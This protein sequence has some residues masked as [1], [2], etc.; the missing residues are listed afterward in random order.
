MNTNIIGVHNRTL[1][2]ELPTRAR[3]IFHGTKYARSR[4]IIGLMNHYAEA[5]DISNASL[6]LYSFVN[7]TCRWLY[8]DRYLPVIVSVSGYLKTLF[9]C[10][11]Y[12]ALGDGNFE[13]DW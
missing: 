9:N 10:V 2:K 3:A 12:T 5:A 13:D 11:R 7:V 6:V 1:K 8:S 4:K